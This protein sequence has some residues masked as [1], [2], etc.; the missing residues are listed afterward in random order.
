[1]T[2][3]HKVSL[4]IVSL[5]ILSSCGTPEQVNINND[6]QNTVVIETNSGT[7]LNENSV[8]PDNENNN[9]NQ[10]AT[11]PVSPYLQKIS[12]TSNEPIQSPLVITGEAKTWYFEGSFPVELH[13]AKGQIISRGVAQAKGD[14]MSDQFVPFSTTL[15]FDMPTT[16][17]G[18]VVF[19]KDNPSGL[20]EY[21]M[22][23]SIP[24]R[25]VTQ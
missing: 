15:N 9:Q 21:E 7:T 1:M 14:W 24:V 10:E 18:T 25:F 4:S 3:F 12:L 11:L 2:T 20:P 13:D 22:S 23:Y 17:T 19:K 16:A 6:N 8:L 5:V